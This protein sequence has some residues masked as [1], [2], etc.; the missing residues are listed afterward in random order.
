M[1]PA[2][3]EGEI[4]A[5]LGEMLSDRGI[6]VAALPRDA[7]IVLT[8]ALDSLD[9]VDLAMELKRRFSVDVTETDTFDTT[10]AALAALV[11]ERRPRP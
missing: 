5:I 1:T 11:V 3:T 2:T 10:L 9:A 7:P 4:R 8:L 6:D